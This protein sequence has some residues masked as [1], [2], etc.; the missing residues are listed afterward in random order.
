MTWFP[1]LM[2]HIKN[3]DKIPL[4]LMGVL[5]H[6]HQWNFFRISVC[7]VTFK[8]SPNPSEVIPKVSGQFLKFPLFV[9]P[10]IA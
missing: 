6:Q 5:T 3:S 9:R 2:D 1:D 8:I 10:N 7:K 4:A